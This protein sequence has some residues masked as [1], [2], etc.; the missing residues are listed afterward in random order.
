MV[1]IKNTGIFRVDAIDE[2]KSQP[3]LKLKPVPFHQAV[4]NAKIRF[5]RKV[6]LAE[7]GTL[8]LQDPKPVE[9]EFDFG[10][11]TI[12]TKATIS[13]E[14]AKIEAKGP[15][16]KG[17]AFGSVNAFIELT[18]MRVAGNIDIVEGE[19]T[20]FRLTFGHV[21]IKGGVG[22]ELTVGVDIPE[23]PL[24][25]PLKVEIPFTVGVVPAKLTIGTA[26]ALTA[27]QSPNGSLKILADF[28]LAGATEFLDDGEQ[29]AS[30]DRD[31]THSTELQEQEV[32]ETVFQFGLTI[33]SIGVKFGNILASTG[34]TFNNAV[35][36]GQGVT[37]VAGAEGPTRDNSCLLLNAT[38]A[39]AVVGEVGFLGLKFQHE[40]E[41]WQ[42]S[43]EFLREG[44]LCDRLV[45]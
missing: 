36:F 10:P 26:L 25:V 39:S 15:F 22:L 29:T 17:I 2:S 8:S 30:V 1:L 40:K 21:N 7:E 13:E 23:G 19:L 20:D 34:F 32:V 12:G 31:Q 5:D 44:G 45:K 35:E 42:D 38:M 11:N 27:R 33:P 43:A 16:N 18:N 6:S 37:F 3:R 14:Q 28:A 9:G 24:E 4:K 41:I